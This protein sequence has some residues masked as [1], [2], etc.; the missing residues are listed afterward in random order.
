M[1]NCGAQRQYDNADQDTESGPYLFLFAR[2]SAVFVL[3]NPVEC[4]GN[5]NPYVPGKYDTYAAQQVGNAEPHRHDAYSCSAL[6]L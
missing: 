1:V 6:Q 2:R 3:G 5:E 4:L